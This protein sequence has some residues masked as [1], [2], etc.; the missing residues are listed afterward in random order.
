MSLFNP[1]CYTNGKETK[2]LQS[3]VSAHNFKVLVLA[4]VRGLGWCKPL[5][6]VLYPMSAN[7]NVIVPSDDAYLLLRSSTKTWIYTG[8]LCCPDL[9]AFV[10]DV[11][12][13]I[14]LP[15]CDRKGFPMLPFPTVRGADVKGFW[16]NERVDDP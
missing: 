4:Q 7:Y 14:N 5:V 12:A 6:H 3:E 13:S 8:M 2:K 11:S 16:F 15:V 10:Q 1:S 9:S